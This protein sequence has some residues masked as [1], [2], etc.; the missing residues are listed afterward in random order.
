M[1]NA[2]YPNFRNVLLSPGVNLAT[3]NIKAALVTLTTGTTNYTYSAAHAN[4][5]DVAAGSIFVAGV[6]LTSLA[7]TA[8]SLT[9]ASVVWPSVAV[10]GTKKA[11]AII[12]YIDN[13]GTVANGSTST[14][15]GYIDTATGLPATPTGQNITL[16]WSSS[17]LTD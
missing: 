14:L 16:N 9:A 17:V 6:A 8:Q 13:T 1:A 3:A 5:S 10:S 4:L 2:V 12:L 15:I 7:V 11:E